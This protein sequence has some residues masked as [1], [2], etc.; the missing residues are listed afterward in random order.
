MMW[1]TDVLVLWI[2]GSLF[3]GNLPRSADLAGLHAR[4]VSDIAHFAAAVPGSDGT[5]VTVHD[6]LSPT[7]VTDRRDVTS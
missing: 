5:D 4:D 3:S 2:F 6:E 1:L 7:R